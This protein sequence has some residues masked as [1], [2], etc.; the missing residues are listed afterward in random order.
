MYKAPSLL[1]PDPSSSFQVEIGANDYAIGVVLYQD[2]KSIEFV[3]KKLDYAQSRYSVQE[4]ELF[5][6]IHALKSWC[7]YLYGN[8]F[9][10]TMD[11]KSLKYFCD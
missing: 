9:V 3:S 11:H 7:H 2:G 10:V 6:V 4:K 5:T 8:R 1:L